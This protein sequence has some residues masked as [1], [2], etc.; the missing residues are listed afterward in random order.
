MTPPAV[1]APSDP[2]RLPYIIGIVAVMGLHASLTV[3]FSGATS[4]STAYLIGI[5][6]GVA[7]SLVVVVVLVL[8]V[9][10]VLGKLKTEGAQARATFWAMTVLL[11]LRVGSVVGQHRSAAGASADTVVTAAERGALQISPDSIWHPAF[12]LVLSQRGASFHPDS[13]LQRSVDQSLAQEPSMVMWGLR[14]TAQNRTLLVEVMKMGQ[15]DEALFRRYAAEIRKGYT[16]SKVLDEAVSWPGPLGEYQ[17]TLQ[18]PSGLYIVLR[19]IPRTDPARPLVVC[20]QTTAQTT[21][22]LD[23]LRRSLRIVD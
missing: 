10:R 6:I 1:P 17:L 12:G 18:H 22:E 15:M 9:G 11:V 2:V 16:K 8:I 23:S 14:D 7:A 4:L 13:A 19:C 20:V 5:L 21:T 3:T